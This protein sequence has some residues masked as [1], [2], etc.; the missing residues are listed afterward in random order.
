MDDAYASKLR[1]RQIN[2]L[3]DSS[4]SNKPYPTPYAVRIGSRAWHEGL[5][6]E[7]IVHGRQGGLV[8]VWF[9]SGFSRYLWFQELKPL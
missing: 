3:I 8:L 5:Q 6:Q 4:T 2:R 9:T 7:V 1:E